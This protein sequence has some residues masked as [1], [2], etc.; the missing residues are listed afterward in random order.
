MQIYTGISYEYAPVCENDKMEDR[1]MRHEK[2]CTA[3]MLDA[4]DGG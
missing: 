3:T 2:E 4:L 1:S